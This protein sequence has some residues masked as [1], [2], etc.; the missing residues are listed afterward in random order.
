[1]IK[2]RLFL[3]LIIL[4]FF[5]ILSCTVNDGTGLILLNNSSNSDIT[6]IKIG[7]ITISGYLPQGQKYDYWYFNTLT[8]T[9]TGGSVASNVIYYISGNQGDT[10]IS[11]SG[12]QIDNFQFKKDYEYEID[13]IALNGNNF[14]CIHGGLKPGD[15]TLNNIDN[16]SN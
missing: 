3:L 2:I 5:G 7:G 1:M 6:N 16:P 10:L 12:S 13:V 11:L 14:F 9:L 15:N 8:G 4:S